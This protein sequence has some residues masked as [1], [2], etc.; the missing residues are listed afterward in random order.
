MTS[1]LRRLFR[2][3]R[4]WPPVGYVEKTELVEHGLGRSLDTTLVP[5]IV[6]CRWAW[7]LSCGGS[8]WGYHDEAGST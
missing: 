7:R 8:W 1:F 3:G 2:R 5:E 4:V 6:R